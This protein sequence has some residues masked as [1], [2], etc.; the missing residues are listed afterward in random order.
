[1]NPFMNPFK[2]FR[3]EAADIGR[4]AIELISKDRAKTHGHALIQHQVAAQMWTA[5]LN[6]RDGN[7]VSISAHE[8]TM[9]LMLLKASR[10]AVGAHNRDNFVDAAGYACLAGAIREFEERDAGVQEGWE[11]RPPTVAEDRGETAAETR[12][13]RDGDTSPALKR[14]R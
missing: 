9:M 10:D 11:D 6:G 8:V 5:Y 3:E 12:G 4:T 7:V 14:Q 2:T 1:M 13:G